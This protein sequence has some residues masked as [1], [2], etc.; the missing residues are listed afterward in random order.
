MSYKYIDELNEFGKPQHLHTLDDKPLIGT[1]SALK[2]LAKPLTWW[3]SGLACSKF[4]WIKKLDTRKNSIEEVEKNKIERLELAKKRFSEIKGFSDEDYL[5]L[6]DEAYKA[7]AE[8]LSDSADKGVDLHAELERYVKNTMKFR[9]D[10]KPYD[11]KIKPFIEWSK[12][13]V[14]KFIASEVHCY[15]SELWTG[16]ICDCIAEL[17]NKCLAIVDFKS[18][19][20]AYD[21]HFI[22]CAGYALQLEENGMFDRDGKVNKKL[23]GTIGELVVFPFGASPVEP[24]IRLNVAQYKEGFK[25]TVALYKLIELH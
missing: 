20:E 5:K 2:V 1:S 16:G 7:H 24:E 6:L 4:G 12:A 11:E 9:F 25:N 15:S 8:K 13:N 18:S 23:D 19:K 17:N 22:Q 3:A 14:K 21:S 10:K